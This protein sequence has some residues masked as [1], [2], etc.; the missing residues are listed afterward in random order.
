MYRCYNNPFTDYIEP[1]TVYMQAA[2]RGGR[3]TCA[4][5]LVNAMHP[6]RA[7]RCPRRRAGEV[8]VKSLHRVDAW[9]L[10]LAPADLD[11]GAE[12]DAGVV[13]KPVQLS[14][15]EPQEHLPGVFEFIH[16]G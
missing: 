4:H 9:V 2:F 13:R 7:G 8:L 5:R 6:A 10:G 12:R 11:K 3:E 15:V 1:D 16:E 14:I